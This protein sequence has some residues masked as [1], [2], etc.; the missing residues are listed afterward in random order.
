LDETQTRGEVSSIP[1]TSPEGAKLGHATCRST[2]RAFDMSVQNDNGSS[3]LAGQQ[4]LPAEITS[5]CKQC[6]K[7]FTIS[8][9]EQQS[10]ARKALSTPARC[11]RCRRQN[12][13]QALIKPGGDI[14]KGVSD[15]RFREALTSWAIKSGW[16]TEA[17]SIEEK[18]WTQACGMQKQQLAETL[19]LLWKRVDKITPLDTK[20]DNEALALALQSQVSFTNAE[21]DE[22]KVYDTVIHTSY[23]SSEDFFFKPAL[24]E[25]P[26]GTVGGSDSEIAGSLVREFWTS[27][28]YGGVREFLGRLRNRGHRLIA[29]WGEEILLETS[30]N[31]KKWSS[32][33]G[34]EQWQWQRA[35]ESCQKWKPQT[36]LTGNVISWNLGPLH[37][38]A[39]L[40]YI[41][42]TM[43]RGA[44]VVLLQEILVRKGTKFKVRRELGQMFPKYECY[45]SVG[46]H[47]DVG[48][49][50]NDET[51]ADEYARNRTQITV[52]TFLHKKVFQSHALTRTWYKPRDMLALEHMA[53]GRVLWLEAKTHDKVSISIVNVHQA[54]AKRHD[55]Q[56]QVTHFLKA[57][58]D[59]ALAQQRIMGGDFNAALSRDGYAQSTSALYE[60]VDKF[61]QDF[62]QSTHGTLIES[63]AH[64]RRDLIKR[65]SASL[66]HIITWNLPYMN[67]CTMQSPISK[68]HW[69]G[70][71]CND[72]ALISCTV[73]GDL[74]TYRKG[75]EGGRHPGELHL[76]K[77][78]TK[79]IPRIQSRLNAIT[80]PIA[81]ETLKSYEAGECS[82]EQAMVHTIDTR[83]TTAR[84]LMHKNPEGRSNRA[85]ERGPHRSREQVRILKEVGTLLAALMSVGKP[86][87]AS[88]AAM[89]CLV[90][91]GIYR[92][93]QMTPQEAHDFTLCPQWKIVLNAMIESLRNELLSKAIKQDRWNNRETDRQAEK[94]FLEEHKGPGKFSGKYGPQPSQT[95]LFWKM[96]W[97]CWF[98]YDDDQILSKAW[99]AATEEFSEDG[100]STTVRQIQGA[101]FTLSASY[102]R[103]DWTAMQEWISFLFKYKSMD[104]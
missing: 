88:A 99:K 93:L 52:V 22:L 95:E 64:T 11:T 55:L 56:R 36:S 44:A 97:G 53:N 80:R 4:N 5:R 35:L 18:K 57:M 94:A 9:G 77:I 76:K 14:P 6:E 21:W 75:Q 83:V 78:D 42:Q 30:G 85:Q 25:K 98:E 104:G 82:A 10:F 66:D 51:L 102:N 63:E 20:I 32:I 87:Q 45:I 65:S 46:N 59:A 19:G 31:P 7:T 100:P 50:E 81:Q 101:R 41:A 37:L 79:Q 70:A 49:D 13:S 1:G 92:D 16:W 15:S 34:W 58:I 29:R 60:K 54:T 12:R 89:Q 28:E 72:H 84:T 39:A 48:N 8:I 33:S 2:H 73:G 90:D 40:P 91:F 23:V 26:A 38:S 27:I 96:A 68:V 71:E 43:Q 24:P 17:R 103:K 74:L 62:V 3:P 86:G 61:F 67:T 47:V 69:V